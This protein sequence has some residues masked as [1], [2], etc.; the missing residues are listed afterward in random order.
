MQVSA[1]PY[2]NSPDGSVSDGS[3]PTEFKVDQLVG[4]FSADP[5]LIAFAQFCCDSTWNTRQAPFTHFLVE[6]GDL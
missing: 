4:T 5:S 1:V 3:K 2:Q 6:F